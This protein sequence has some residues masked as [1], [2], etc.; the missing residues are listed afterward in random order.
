MAFPGD[1]PAKL[2]VRLAGGRLLEQAQPKVAG[3]PENPMPPEEYERKFLDN[4]ARALGQA[5]A[6]ALL[7]KLRDLPA[8][9]D[10]STLAP[11]YA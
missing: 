8:L 1:Y 11:F 10:L 3:T 5:R 2:R 4:A 7:G 6:Q 9:R